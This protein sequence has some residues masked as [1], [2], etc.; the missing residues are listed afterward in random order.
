ETFQIWD[1]VAKRLLGAYTNAPGIPVSANNHSFAFFG[2]DTVLAVGLM[3]GVV[4]RFHP[5]TLKEVAPPLHVTGE[6]E[7][8]YYSPD[9]K[10]LLVAAIPWNRSVPSMRFTTGRTELTWFDTADDRIVKK[11]SFP[12]GASWAMAA[13]QR[14]AA[15]GLED[16][17]ME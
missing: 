10:A 1:L 11:M 17:T 12:V 9:G 2:D 14:M 15:V 13:N 3:G 8:V 16:G 5:R 4:R 7:D 6:I